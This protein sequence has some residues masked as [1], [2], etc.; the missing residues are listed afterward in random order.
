MMQTNITTNT[1][2]PQGYSSNQRTTP[3]GVE[4]KSRAGRN[5]RSGRLE[6][7]KMQRRRARRVR[8]FQDARASAGVFSNAEV[9]N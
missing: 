9:V 1:D 3:A 2:A 6:S 7:I 4:L 5:E 8:C